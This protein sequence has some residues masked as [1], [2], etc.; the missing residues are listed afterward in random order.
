MTTRPASIFLGKVFA[1]LDDNPACLDFS[2]GPATHRIAD[3]V[4]L[5]PP[6]LL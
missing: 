4:N 5:L 1:T 3:A 2:Q 6:I